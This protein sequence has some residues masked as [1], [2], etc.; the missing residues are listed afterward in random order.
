[1]ISL[2]KLCELAGL[3]PRET[4]VIVALVLNGENSI[5]LAEKYNVTHNTINTLERRGQRK[6]HAYCI[7]HDITPEVIHEFG[8]C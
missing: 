7:E 1:M 4:Q 8:V 3:S 5:S 6:L 2:E